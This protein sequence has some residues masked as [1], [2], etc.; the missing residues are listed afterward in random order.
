LKKNFS[1]FLALRYLRPRGT[2]VSIITLISLAGVTLGVGVLVVVI[3]VMTGFEI[4]IKETILGMEPHISLNLAGEGFAIG[5]MEEDEAE[6]SGLLQSRWDKVRERFQGLENVEAV[7]PFVEGAVLIEV[8]VNGEKRRRAQMMRGVYLGDEAQKAQLRKLMVDGAEPELDGDK[9]LISKQLSRT[10]GLR[11][12]DFMTLV[13]SKNVEELLNA[14]DEINEDD[15]IGTEAKGGAISDKIKQL[16]VPTELEVSGFFDSPWFA[17]VVVVPLEIAQDVYSLGPNVHG[18]DVQLKD[19]YRANEILQKFNEADEIPP[20][21]IGST[22]MERNADKFAAI[23]N[24]RAM[25][26]FVLFFI[27]LVAAFSIMNTMITV[28]VQK[29]REIG[30]MKALGAKSNQIIWVFLSQGMIVGI[31]G[32]L[33]GLGLGALVVHYR[34]EVRAFF[35]EVFNREIFPEAVYGVTEI[36]AKIVGTDVAIIAVGAFL[37]CSLAALV[38]AMV[39]ARLDAA[40]A[41]RD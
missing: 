19:A 6:A 10:M 32:T 21:W 37:L 33:S 28:T 35:A 9:V 41:L 39:A 8:D 17:E 4:K 31:S 14:V 24:E 1:L 26:Y 36:P 23:R 3:A 2:A 12:G 29:R 16:V 34:N 5:R 38:P 27:V 22:W 40:K 20:Y 25:L 18:L 15:T 7:F 30:V 11:I 13:S